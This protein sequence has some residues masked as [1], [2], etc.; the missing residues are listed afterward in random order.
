MVNPKKLLE[1]MLGFF[2]CMPHC[3]RI[4]LHPKLGFLG[5]DFWDWNTMFQGFQIGFLGGGGWKRGFSGLKNILKRSDLEF[6]GE[7]EIG[8]MGGFK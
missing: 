8:L 2:I 5:F 7:S 1:F 4:F 3:F 6:F